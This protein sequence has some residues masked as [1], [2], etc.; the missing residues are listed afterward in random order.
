MTLD[1]SMRYLFLLRDGG[2]ERIAARV[3]NGQK[4]ET[5][6]YLAKTLC[7]AGWWRVIRSEKPL[8]RRG[9]TMVLEVEEP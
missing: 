6:R 3:W 4:W 8:W 7:G 5:R 9:P 2:G 1:H